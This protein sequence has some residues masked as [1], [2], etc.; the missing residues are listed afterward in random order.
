MQQAVANTLILQARHQLEVVMFCTE[1]DVQ[2]AVV[3][4]VRI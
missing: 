1:D 3:N 2:S 4:V